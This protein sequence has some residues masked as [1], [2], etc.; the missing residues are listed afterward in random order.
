MSGGIWALLREL[1]RYGKGSACDPTN[2]D[3]DVCDESWSLSEYGR[4]YNWHAVEDD[5][6]LCP[7]GWHVPTDGEW[8]VMTDH[9]GGD[10][11][12]GHQMKTTYGWWG[13]GNG[14]NLSGFSGLP[15][16]FRGSNGSFIEAGVYGIWWSS[17]AGSNASAWY[18][19]ID[20]SFEEVFRSDGNRGA[21]FS[22]RCIKDSE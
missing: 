13:G 6:G 2:P 14:T 9:L 3:G 11:V 5:R 4:L 16:G 10:S 19:S 12:A 22:V 15:G 18:R 8:T 1:Y 7:D 17:S 21:G 20:S